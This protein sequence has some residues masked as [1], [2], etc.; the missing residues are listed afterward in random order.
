M[1][2]L[3]QKSTVL[4]DVKLKY[5]ILIF[6]LLFA[7][8]FVSS[9]VLTS[10]LNNQSE[11]MLEDTEN[12]ILPS[13]ETS[14]RVKS[15]LLSTQKAI[16]D[17][18]A[19]ADESKLEVADAYSKELVSLCD[20]LKL[21][22]ETHPMTDSI[23]KAFNGYYT[24]A[25]ETAK[26]Y[27]NEGFSEEAN[28]KAKGINPAFEAT[29]G[30]INR[31]E[32][33]SKDVAVSHFNNIEENFSRTFLFSSLI[34]VVGVLIM[35]ITSYV[36]SNAIVGPLNDL[37][38]YM[39]KISRKRINFNVNADRKDEIGVLFESVNEINKNFKDIVN[40]MNETASHVLSAGAQLSNVSQQIAESTNEQAATTE[41]ISA[42]IEQM[43]ANISQNSEN[44]QET[45]KTSKLVTEDV[46]NVKIS[47]DE[48]LK[49]LKE[50]TV[51]ISV[52]NEIADKTDLLAINASIEAAK[53]GEYGKG[54][55]VVATEIRN[56][57]EQSLKAALSIETLSNTTLDIA[58]KTGGILDVAI[59]RI[60][61][62]IQ[63]INEIAS[64]SIEQN[65]GANLINTSVQQLV[66]VTNQNLATAEQ[67]SENAEELTGQAGALKDIIS[68]FNL[69]G[70]GKKKTVR[71][72]LKQTD[73]FKEIIAQ[74]GES[75][76][77]GI[78]ENELTE[79]IMKEVK[80]QKK[81]K[82]KIKSKP[83]ENDADDTPISG[84]KID[85]EKDQN[86]TDFE[87]Y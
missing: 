20:S 3:K 81:I 83:I 53:A 23:S 59:P 47:F 22:G 1:I 79:E 76:D 8:L 37:V 72:L 87:K 65:E 11:D 71:Q 50:I 54:F 36:I 82:T 45:L 43:T 32:K 38:S 77:E 80:S 74:L 73:L 40:N 27:I 9:F 85:M 18:L 75:D 84:A 31:F 5:K 66:G 19:S 4:K 12:V 13:I 26:L 49:A 63:L 56:L 57:S 46:G 61:K 70:D 64:A 48:T 68:D 16:G 34:A 28:E 39:K 78:S 25:T 15:L 69:D 29:Q 44:S 35:L 17:A 7:V 2:V 62:T 24:I 10:M 33:H 41:Q 60:Q 52:I 30:I 6:P 21:D 67:M 55:A 58:G 42:S 86:D 51:K 14:I